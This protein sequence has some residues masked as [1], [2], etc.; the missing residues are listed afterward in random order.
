M[1]EPPRAAFLAE[2]GSELSPAVRLMGELWPDVPLIEVPLPVVEVSPI[3][4]AVPVRFDLSESVPLP[5]PE[6]LLP[7]VPW[8]DDTPPVPAIAPV[9]SAVLPV[10]VLPVSTLRFRLFV[11]LHPVQNSPTAIASTGSSVF[12]MWVLRL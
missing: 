4:V 12:L 5:E 10:P 8:P 2:L 9:W 3:P 6:P 7:I 1:A 11:S